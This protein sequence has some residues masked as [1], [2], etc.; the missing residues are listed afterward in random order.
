MNKKENFTEDCPFSS[1]G[2]GEGPIPIK[3]LGV[4]YLF[5]FHGSK[6]HFIFQTI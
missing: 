1:G 5:F 6:S 2:K 3:K 4:L